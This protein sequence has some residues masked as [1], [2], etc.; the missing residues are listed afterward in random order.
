ML[1]LEH[2]GLWNAWVRIK[3]KK[4]RNENRKGIYMILSKHKEIKSK[5]LMSKLGD[6]VIRHPFILNF[7][8]SLQVNSASV[9]FSKMEMFFPS[10][11]PSR[12]RWDNWDVLT[13]MRCV[14]RVNWFNLCLAEVQMVPLVRH[15]LFHVSMPTCLQ[16]W[17]WFEIETEIRWSV[18]PGKIKNIQI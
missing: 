3:V 11:S 9:C 7:V 18:V 2:E 12:I 17:D 6:S 10:L 8:T 4:Y 13:E 15:Y 14:Y 1:C 5:I 16:F